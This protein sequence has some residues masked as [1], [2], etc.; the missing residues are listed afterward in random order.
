MILP[1][2][3]MS[4]SSFSKVPLR[5]HPEEIPMA[6]GFDYPIGDMDGRGWNGVNVKGW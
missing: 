1:V 2:R 3:G 5:M 6:S 4:I